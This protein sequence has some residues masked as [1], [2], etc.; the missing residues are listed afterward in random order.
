LP[1]FQ[2]NCFLGL[3]INGPPKWGKQIGIQYQFL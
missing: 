3:R 2:M 1:I